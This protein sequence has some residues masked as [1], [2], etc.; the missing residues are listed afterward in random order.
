MH[1]ALSLRSGQPWPWVAI[2]LGLVAGAVK[3]HFLFAG[4][5]RKNLTRIDDLLE[6][7]MWQFFRPRFFIFLAAMITIGAFLSRISHGNYALLLCVAGLDLCIATALLG[8]SYV[9]WKAKAN[10]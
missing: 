1:E 6:P 10:K 5:C 4:T 3:A 8:S 9:F 2:A 7:K